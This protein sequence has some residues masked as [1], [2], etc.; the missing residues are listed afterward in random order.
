[1]YADLW[2]EMEEGM[3]PK[4]RRALQ[5]ALARN[6]GTLDD[7]IENDNTVDSKES[8]RVESLLDDEKEYEESE[9]DYSD[10]FEDHDPN[11]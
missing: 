4:E 10:F 8:R 9:I 1:M 11:F 5:R 6:S 2:D 3:S 7:L